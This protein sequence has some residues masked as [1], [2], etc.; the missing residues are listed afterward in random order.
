[1]IFKLGPNGQ[2]TYTSH[3][4]NTKHQNMNKIYMSLSFRGLFLQ[5]HALLKVKNNFQNLEM[6]LLKDTRF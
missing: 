2:Y 6:V 4:Q 1:M 5:S 3:A